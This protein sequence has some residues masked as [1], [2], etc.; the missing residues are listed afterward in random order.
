MAA[1]IASILQG[2]TDINGFNEMRRNQRKDKSWEDALSEWQY[3]RDQMRGVVMAFP[4][5]QYDVPFNTP[6]MQKTN[7]DASHQRLWHSREKRT[8]A[9]S[10][11]RIKHNR[12]KIVSIKEL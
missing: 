3:A 9:K 11:T 4:E 8:S 12:F 1:S 7:I 2:Q 6:F 5:A 10:A